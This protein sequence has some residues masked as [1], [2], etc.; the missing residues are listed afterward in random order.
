[1]KRKK[2]KAVCE[3]LADVRAIEDEYFAWRMSPDCTDWLAARN[4]LREHER[5]L[6][7]AKLKGEAALDA[8]AAAKKGTP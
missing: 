3:A 4:K 1:M 6:D 5:R 7:E 8:W 2:V